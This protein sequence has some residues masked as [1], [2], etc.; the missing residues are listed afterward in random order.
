[1]KL[2]GEIDIG[3]AGDMAAVLA[4]DD[5]E[6]TLSKIAGA[7]EKNREAEPVDRDWLR[8]VSELVARLSDLKERYT[9]GTS[10]RGRSNMGI[11][12]ATGCTSVWGST[13]PFNPYPFP[14]ANHLFQDSPSMA[15]G[16]FEGH[17]AKMAEGFKAIRRAEL[18]LVG[19]VAYQLVPDVGVIFQC[20][21]PAD[22]EAISGFVNDRIV[23][24]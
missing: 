9:K 5:G 7:V 23:A 6:L 8:Q 1:M 20:T 13:Y 12:N 15:M 18:E 22:R 19:E 17:M 21:A 3:D 4:A 2:V 24:A 14:W 16:I 10:G 11:L